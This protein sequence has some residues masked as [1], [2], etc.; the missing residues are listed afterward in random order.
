MRS[1]NIYMI[2]IK[3]VGM[4]MLA[5][6]LASQGHR[7]SGSDISDVFLTDKVLKK[8][9]ILVKTP[10]KVT[11]L[12]DKTD[13]VIYSSAFKEDNNVELG[14]LFAQKDDKYKKTEILSYAQ[15][16]GGIFNTY[17][18]CLLYTSPSP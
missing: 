1:K 15:A 5:Q 14:K 11:N 4:T 16:L 6:F 2:G 17:K 13:I 7:V 3:G 18:G 10:F 9:G 8:S 12:P